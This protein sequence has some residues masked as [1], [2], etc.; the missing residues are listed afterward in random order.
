MSKYINSGWVIFNE[1]HRELFKKFK[2]FYLENSD[3]FI[4]FI[5]VR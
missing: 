4:K 5:K 1:N 2:D 3:E